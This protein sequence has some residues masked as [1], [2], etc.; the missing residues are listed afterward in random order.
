MIY[1]HPPGGGATPDGR[2]KDEL[3]MGSD[4]LEVP[5]AVDRSL[6]LSPAAKPASEEGL[7]IGTA[8]VLH[9]KSVM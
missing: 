9:P 3:I 2:D 6:T 5:V 1:P 4:D 7:T 8:G